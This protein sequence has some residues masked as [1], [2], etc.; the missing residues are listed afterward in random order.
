MDTL[1]ALIKTK[2]ALRS[3]VR[4]KRLELVDAAGKC[5][6][7]R[8]KCNHML[9]PVCDNN[10]WEGIKGVVFHLLPVQVPG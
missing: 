6:D 8:D 7:A 5:T 10:F 3:L 1:T 4:K 9:E 2:D